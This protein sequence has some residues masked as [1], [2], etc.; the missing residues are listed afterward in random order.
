MSV[1]KI[2]AQPMSKD[3]IASVLIQGDLSKLD[4]E[5]RLSYYTQLCD[6]LGLDP[7]TRPLEYIKLQGKE[8]LYFR[9]D[10]TEQ[11]RKKHSITIDKMEDKVIQDCVYVVTAYA[12]DKEGR[13]DV[14]KG[15]VSISGLKGDALAN[16]IMKAET[17]AKRRVTLSICGVGF[18]DE[19]EIDTIPEVKA[20][21]QINKATKAIETDKTNQEVV[22]IAAEEVMRNHL[23]GI[24][25]SQSIEE[26]HNKFT[27]AYKYGKSIKDEKFTDAV[28]TLKDMKKEELTSNIE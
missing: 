24:E 3:V 18:L 2:E 15:A 13:T 10:A 22:P 17:K 26:L 20:Q 9:K 11:L 5:Q 19:S 27:E 12:H 21:R 14:A 6:R 16:A 23:D 4:T 1:Q 7:I 25:K 8:T 28:I